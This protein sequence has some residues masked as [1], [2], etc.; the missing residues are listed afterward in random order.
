V[1]ATAPSTPRWDENH[2]RVRVDRGEEGAFMGRWSGCGRRWLAL[3]GNG[4]HG[5]LGNQGGSSLVPIPSAWPN[6]WAPPALVACGGAHTACVDQEGRIAATGLDEDGQCARRT[7]SEIPSNSTAWMEMNVTRGS[8]PPAFVKV[9]AGHFHTLALDQHGHVWSCGKNSRGQ[10]GTGPQ[11]EKNVRELTRIDALKSKR[12]VEIAAGA[13]HSLAVCEEGNLYAWGCSAHGR[14]GVGRISW[15]RGYRECDPRLVR[16]ISGMKM[17]QISAGHMASACVDETGQAYTFGYG[18]HWQLG[19]VDDADAWT[20]APVPELHSVS[21]ITMGGMHAA[22]I[23]TT[24]SLLIW[25][26]NDSGSLGLGIR[27]APAAKTPVQ[28][29]LER[30]NFAS[31]SCGWRHTAA[32][33]EEGVLYTWGWGGFLGSSGSEEDSTGGQLGHGGV[34]D[35]WAPQKVYA[36]LGP[37]EEN[38]Q[39]W[40]QLRQVSCGFN[41]TGA[42]VEDDLSIEQ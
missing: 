33:T 13:E 34:S 39:S 20:P 26:T 16:G 10:C 22:A 41:H 7:S 12:I 35:H 25:G 1:V 28:T 24:G 14:L 40:R 15:F 6:D 19:R 30:L 18:R 36:F 9:A 38:N 2:P 17:V 29:T 3:W 21:N 11:S 42:I 4:D 32:I 37:E 31:V 27:G 8:T 5:R 23:T